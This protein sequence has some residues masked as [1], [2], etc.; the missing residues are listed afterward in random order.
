MGRRGRFW[1]NKRNG[2]GQFKH[3]EIRNRN[4]EFANHTFA[5]CY[6]ELTGVFGI[7]AD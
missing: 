1:E 2:K 7:A 5:G 3:N 6:V 4:Q